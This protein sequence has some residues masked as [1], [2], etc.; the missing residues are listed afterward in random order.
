MR[1]MTW[2][3]FW[4]VFELSRY[5]SGLPCTCRSRIGKSLR[6]RSTSSAA[7]LPSR[8]LDIAITLLKENGSL[9]VP[10][11]ARLQTELLAQPFVSFPLELWGQLGAAREHDP[12]LHHDVDRVGGDVIE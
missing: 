10:C 2:R 4:L 12:A 7:G 3:G 6:I 8:T 11:L 9:F 5:T 1:S